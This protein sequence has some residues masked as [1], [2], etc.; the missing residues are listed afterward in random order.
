LFDVAVF[1]H[2]I[3]AISF[4]MAAFNL[5]GQGMQRNAEVGLFT[6]PSMSVQKQCP[7]F[8]YL[9]FGGCCYL[10][11]FFSPHALLHLLNSH[12]DA[13][14][15]HLELTGNL[16]RIQTKLFRVANLLML[17]TMMWCKPQGTS[18]RACRGIK[19]LLNSHQ[20]VMKFFVI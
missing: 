4:D 16:C 14:N 11:C 6:K 9:N 19:I 17:R 1:K 18:K 2:L 5:T 15:G 20:I 7:L 12:Y 8:C 13:R 10:H 3:Y